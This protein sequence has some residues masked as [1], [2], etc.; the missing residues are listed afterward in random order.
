VSLVVRETAKIDLSKLGDLAPGAS[1]PARADELLG[2]ASDRSYYRLFFDPPLPTGPTAVLMVLSG[3]GC[4]DRSRE[5]PYINVQRHLKNAGIP[6]P[7]IYRYD[8]DR[9]LLLTEDVGDVSMEDRLLRAGPAE[10]ETL[11]RQAIDILIAIQESA[12]LGS[13]TE[14]VAFT[15]AFDVEKLMW[16][17][18][19]FLEHAVEGLWE[20]KISEQDRERIKAL[21]EEV[22]AE[23]AA[24]P[25][26]FVHRDFHSRNLMVRDGA[27]VVLDFQDARLGP[28]TYD[29][30]S[31]LRDSYHGLAEGLFE[32]LIDYY[33]DRREASRA[34][35]FDRARF[36]ERFDLMALQ[37][38]LKAIGTFAFQKVVKG[39]SR[40]LPYI[41]TTLG[42]VRQNLSRHPRH[43]ELRRLLVSYIDGLE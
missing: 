2:D 5:L 40:Y 14:C 17:L 16:E 7:E 8:E 22:C 21:F 27:L 9:G 6:V 32:S 31:L 23:L 28:A 19:F 33:L 18:R 13:E 43:E 39:N 38:N 4:V 10:R 36:R 41:P 1:R 30:A 12:S 25:R 42:Y 34:R 35:P 3:E 20:R 29:L 15:L 11:Y 24:E 26:V 37:R